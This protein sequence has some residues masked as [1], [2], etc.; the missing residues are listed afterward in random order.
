ML[1]NQWKESNGKA[2]LTFEEN[3]ALN[4]RAQ[5]GWT[6][7]NHT[8]APVP[9]FAKGKGAERF[10]GRIDNSDIKGLILGK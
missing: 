5:I 1:E 6:T 2:T 3:K 9:V 10:Q 7:S 4:D 8:G